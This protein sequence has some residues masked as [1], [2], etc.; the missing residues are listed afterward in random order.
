MVHARGGPLEGLL[1]E[2]LQALEGASRKEVGFNGPEAAFFTG[3]SVGVLE[4]M[5]AKDKT[6]F[7]GEGLHLRMDERIGPRAAQPRQIGV[8]NDALAGGVTPEDQRPMAK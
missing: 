3:F 6:V 8:I 4:G 7:P 5:A 1:V 2:V